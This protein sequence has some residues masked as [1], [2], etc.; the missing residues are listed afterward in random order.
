[1][2][3]GV[4]LTSRLV[5]VPTTLQL[6]GLQG[7]FLYCLFLRAL[8][9]EAALLASPQQEGAH[10]LPVGAHELVAAPRH[11]KPLGSESPGGSEGG[12]GGGKG[13]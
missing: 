1:M 11:G 7:G 8:G 9:W 12:G 6:G 13:A 4:Q 3:H 10:E 2:G 5:V